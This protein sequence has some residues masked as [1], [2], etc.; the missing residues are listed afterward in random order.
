MQVNLMYNVFMQQAQFTDHIKIAIEKPSEK[1][2]SSRKKE[3]P[4]K[5]NTT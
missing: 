3:F 4:L 1:T 5:Y 2:E